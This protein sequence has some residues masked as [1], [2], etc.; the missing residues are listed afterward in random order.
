MSL[1]YI[2]WPSAEIRPMDGCGPLRA[3]GSG[4][5]SPPFLVTR[6]NLPSFR[7]RSQRPSGD[8]SAREL[9]TGRKHSA[10]PPWA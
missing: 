8:H 3:G 1:K 7:T 10:S 4:K 5:G 9:T 6:Y 2:D